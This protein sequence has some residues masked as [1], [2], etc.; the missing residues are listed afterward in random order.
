MGASAAYA[1]QTTDTTLKQSVRRMT[2]MGRCYTIGG[3]A[4]GSGMIHPNMA[5]T[6]GFI[7]TDAAISPEDLQVCLKAATEKSF[8]RITV[9]GDTS[10]NDMISAM[11]NGASGL[12]LPPEAIRSFQ[13]GLTEV[14]IDLARQVASDGEGANRLITVRVTAQ[15]TR[16]TR[17]KSR[18]QCQFSPCEDCGAWCGCKLGTN[19]RGGRAC[20]GRYEPRARR[21]SSERS[22]ASRTGL[23]L[24]FD[25]EEASRRLSE[26]EVVIRVDLEL[27]KVKRRHGHAISL[28]TIFVS[29]LHTVPKRGL[30]GNEPAR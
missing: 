4:K 27:V 12:K 29:T 5:T 20:W 1:I 30:W 13:Q 7:T 9:D 6:L 28:R 14:L 26:D 15:R 24:Q 16:P 22:C 17:S 19:Y 25:E 11:A 21:N 10:T 2:W 18:E 3:M 8:N 23:S